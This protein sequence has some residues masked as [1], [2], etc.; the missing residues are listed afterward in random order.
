MFGHATTLRRQ[1]ISSAPLPWLVLAASGPDNELGW[2]DFF[3]FS[4]FCMRAVCT[5]CVV[6]VCALCMRPV[7]VICRCAECVPCVVCMH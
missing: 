2:V 1:K 5:P 3:F 7:F 4:G 6:F